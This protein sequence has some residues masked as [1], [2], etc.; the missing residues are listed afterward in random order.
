MRER[1]VR[2]VRTRGRTAAGAREWYGIE[3]YR[4]LAGGAGRADDAD[5]GALAM[6]GGRMGFGFSEFPARPAVVAVTS[7][8]RGA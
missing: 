1:Q 3:D 7:L 6:V 5:L 4:P 2:G 8:F